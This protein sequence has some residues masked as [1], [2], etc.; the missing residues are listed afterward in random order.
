MEDPN[1]HILRFLQYCNTIKQHGVTSDHIRQMMFPFSLKDK[2]RQWLNILNMDT[3]TSW[4]YLALAIYKKYYPPERTATL[5][6]QITNF[7][8]EVDESF[9]DAWERFKEL[10]RLCP[11]HGIEKWLLV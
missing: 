8:Q 2:A 3:I 6:S 10:Q 5:R 4:G 11:H 9:Y 1:L 7:N